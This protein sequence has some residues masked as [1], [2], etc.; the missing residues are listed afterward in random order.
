MFKRIMVALDGSPQALSALESAQALADAFGAELHLVSVEVPHFPRGPEWKMTQAAYLD[1]K[2]KV[3]REYLDHWAEKLGQGGR[4]VSTEVLPPGSTVS[5]LQ[6]ELENYRADLLI[7]SSHGRTG[8]LRLLFGSI[9]EEMNRRAICPVL[10]VHPQEVDAW[11][12]S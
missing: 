8:V 1:K 10:I 6:D 12:H 11:D 9:A 7:L 4:T 5:R 3:L 2:H